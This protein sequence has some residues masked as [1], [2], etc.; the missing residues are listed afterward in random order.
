MVAAVSLKNCYYSF[1]QIKLTEI[2]A[3]RRD[4]NDVSLP[5]GG[6]A[7]I[8][9]IIDVIGFVKPDVKNRSADIRKVAKDVEVVVLER[10]RDLDRT[11]ARQLV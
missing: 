3:V 4:D 5:D 8:L 11:V 2:T 6:I 10:R 1:S 7:F 9:I